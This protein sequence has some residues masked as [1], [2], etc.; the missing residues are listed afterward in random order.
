MARGA[1]RRKPL[2]LPDRGPFVAIL[3]LHRGMRTKQ[4][5]AVLVLFNLLNRNLPAENG[6]T[7]R[8]I[9]SEFSPVN[10]RMAVCAVF[11]D[12]RENRLHMALRA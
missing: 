4:R 2:I 6:V 5:E 9:R 10:V 1:G 7:L 8:A 11:P 3:A 12:I